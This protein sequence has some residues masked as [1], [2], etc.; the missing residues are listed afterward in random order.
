MELR[1]N[2]KGPGSYASLTAVRSKRKLI[3]PAVMPLTFQCCLDT[4]VLSA[5]FGAS[6]IHILVRAQLIK[7]GKTRKDPILSFF[8]FYS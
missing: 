4:H 6:V 5:T 1:Y 8:K 3:P 7:N 2:V